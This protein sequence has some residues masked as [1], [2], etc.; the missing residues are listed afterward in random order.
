MVP[1][2]SDLGVRATTPLREALSRI[3]TDEG[4]LVVVVDEQGIVRGV[5]DEEAVRMHVVG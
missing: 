2:T 3:A 1:W 4:Q 5:L